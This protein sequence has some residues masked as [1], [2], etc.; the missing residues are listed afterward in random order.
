MHLTDLKRWQHEHYFNQDKKSAEQKALFVVILTTITMLIEIIAG[1]IFNSMALF[2]DGWHMSTHATALSISLI[3]YILSRK[4]SNDK[5]FTFGSWKIEILAAYTSAILLGVAGLFL[6]GASIERFFKP[7]KISYN[8]ALIVAFLGLIVNI[9]S[10]L[11]LGYE[12]ENH[13]HNDEE[14]YHHHKMDLNL[15][16]AYLHVLADGLTSL[17]AILALLGAKYFGWNWLDPLM[18]IIGS[19]LILRWT[20]LLIKDTSFI[21]LDREMDSPIVREIIKIIESDGDSKISDLHI[22]RVSQN[23]YACILSIVAKNPL[24]IGDYKNKLKEIK[25]LAH[26]TI[27]INHCNE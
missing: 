13:I 4:L 7:L 20:F 1:W 9:I 23:K 26:I 25:E 3:G 16:S 11:I 2:A 5:R 19:F 22:L 8:Q 27:E 12:H 10:A 6:L 14:H 21:L 18:G 24:T 17:F 15:K